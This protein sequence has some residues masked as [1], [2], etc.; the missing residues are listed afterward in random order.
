MSKKLVCSFLF[1]IAFAMALVSGNFFNANA[2][3]GTYFSDSPCFDS[4]CQA[5]SADRDMDREIRMNFEKN[6]SH[7]SG[8]VGYGRGNINDF[9]HD[10]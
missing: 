10:F 9:S 4:P 5:T 2:A 6:S 8:S 1:A 3:G 7:S